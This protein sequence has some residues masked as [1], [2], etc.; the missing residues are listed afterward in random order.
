MSSYNKDYLLV[1]DGH[2]QISIYVNKGK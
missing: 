2:V 1:Y